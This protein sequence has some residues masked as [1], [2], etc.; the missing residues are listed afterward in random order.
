MARK[1]KHKKVVKRPDIDLGTPETRRRVTADPLLSANID[2][3]RLQSALAI[4]AAL[5]DGLGARA[6]DMVRIGMGGGASC[7]ERDFVPTTPHN[8]EHRTCLERWRLACKAAD[9]EHH[10]VE[11]WATG[12]SLRQIAANVP[13]RRTR[14]AEIVDQGLDLYADL[15][16]YRRS[17]RLGARMAVW[18]APADVP[19]I[20]DPETP[21]FAMPV[22]A[23]L[24]NRAFRNDNKTREHYEY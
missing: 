13:L 22:K 7:G 23:A 19:P 3:H 1:N 4:R 20:P 5:E 14:C 17:P 24:R 15:R 12:I 16:G 9:I 10:I 2:P 18:E 6:L 8:I 11:L 21:I